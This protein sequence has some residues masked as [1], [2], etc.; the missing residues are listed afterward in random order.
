MDALPNPFT[1]NT[2]ESVD[3]L[4]E[5]G[6]GGSN[7]L[8]PT[9]NINDLERAE[10]FE[11]QRFPPRKSSVSPSSVHNH[12]HTPSDRRAFARP[13]IPQT[14]GLPIVDCH[15]QALG[16]AR[17]LT[18]NERLLSAAISTGRR[19]TCVTPLC[20][21]LDPALRG[22]QVINRRLRVRRTLAPAISAPLLA[23]RGPT[24]PLS[25]LL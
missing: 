18:V 23:S 15:S 21:G 17:V 7:P 14:W 10:E 3:C 6:A 13:Q 11:T 12:D 9:N 5:A 24:A 25:L 22:L 2:L 20:W 16:R 1:I 8:T 19:N 4:R